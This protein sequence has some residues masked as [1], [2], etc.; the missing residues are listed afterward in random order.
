[1]P[2]KKAPPRPAELRESERGPI[3]KDNPEQ[4]PNPVVERRVVND[5]VYQLEWVRCGK[6]RCR[7]MKG[8]IPGHGPYWYAY[9]PR[10]R[11]G[12]KA[13]KGGAWVSVYIGAEFRELE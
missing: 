8:L 4:R 2:R 3:R 1:M 5:V 6:A 7:C 9:K 10:R 13:T 11:G 12:G